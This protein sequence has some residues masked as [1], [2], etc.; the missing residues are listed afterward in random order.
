[1]R[2]VYVGQRIDLTTVVSP[3]FRVCKFLD[4]HAILTDTKH[5]AA[6]LLTQICIPSASPFKEIMLQPSAKTS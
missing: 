2:L 1:M 5:L 6:K 4:E 3:R